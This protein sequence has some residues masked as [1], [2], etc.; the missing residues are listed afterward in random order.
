MVT[1]STCTTLINDELNNYYW[2]VAASLGLTF[3]NVL[4]YRVL[5]RDTLGGS[6]TLAAQFFLVT[7]TIKVLLGV[8]LLVFFVPTCPSDCTCDESFRPDLYIYPF[9]AIVIGVSWIAQGRSFSQRAQ[10]VERSYDNSTNDTRSTFDRKNTGS[11]NNS[12][13]AIFQPVSTLEIA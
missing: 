7:G 11:N 13:P 2:L 6:P 9:V 8:I 4:L 5:L 12:D 10:I 1:Q 3:G